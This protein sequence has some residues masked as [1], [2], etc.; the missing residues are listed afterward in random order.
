MGAEWGGKPE[1]RL[2]DLRATI[3][4]LGREG[5][6]LARFLAERGARV[7]VSDIKPPEALAGA[8]AQLRGLDL[9]YALGG[10]P[11][12]ILAADVLFLSPGVP[13]DGPVAREARRRGVA[14][15]SETRLFT[16]L[17]PA[18]IVGITGSSGKTTTT[19][20][21]GKMLEAAGQRTWV[22]GNIGQPLIGRLGEIG[23]GDAV[24]MELS[25]FQ[26]EG[27]GPATPPEKAFPP[28]GWSPAGAAILNITPNHLDRHP[29]MEAYV[30]AKANILRYQRSGDWAVLNADD[31]VTQSLRGQCVGQVLEFSLQGPVAAGAWLQGDELVWRPQAG[32]GQA[33]C[34][35]SE[36]RL[37]GRH[38]IA[39]MLAA[40]AVSGAMGVGIEAM[41][42]V[43]TTFTGVEHRL[44]LV[45]VVGGVSYYNDSI[46]T[47]PE[48]A[49]AAIESFTEPLVLLA[50]GRDKH[51]PWQT[52]AELVCRRV[53]E[54]VCFGEMVPLLERVLAE[55]GGGP[56]VHACRTLAEAVRVAAQVAR[57]GDVVLLSPGGTSFDAFPDFVARGEAFKAAVRELGAA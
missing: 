21:V 23:P 16:R 17:C 53:R 6:A 18:P 3:I 55:A 4:G 49:I 27:F 10:H 43:A 29:S 1:L 50:G 14:V 33:I 5:T 57:P 46:A 12:W 26:L 28:G 52:W 34:K 41:R 32:A 56:P 2:A 51:L 36:V 7:T 42:Q 39:N 13:A 11:D 20:L 44:E 24:V 54:V 47:S 37:R 45:R 15:S 30:A 38:N 19:T 35:V 48:R 31:P 8:I 22:G 25:S 9:C 40:C